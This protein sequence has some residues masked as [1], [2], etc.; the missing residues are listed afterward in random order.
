[1][2]DIINHYLNYIKLL[3]AERFGKKYMVGW[4]VLWNINARMLFNTWMLTMHR[5]KKL[6][7]NCT[8]MLQAILNKILEATSQKTAAVSSPTNHLVNHPNQM[9]K[10]C[11]TLLEE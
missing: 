7:G 4:F 6:D 11:G 1:M 8:R 9:N 2:I 5:N 10:T 3:L